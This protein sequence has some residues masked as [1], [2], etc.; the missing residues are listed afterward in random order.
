LGNGTFW[1]KPAAALSDVTWDN[2]TFTPKV[3]TDEARAQ[4]SLNWNYISVSQPEKGPSKPD[5]AQSQP[6]TLQSDRIFE[7]MQSQYKSGSEAEYRK[8][9]MAVVPGVIIG[10]L[11]FTLFGVYIGYSIEKRQIYKRQTLAARY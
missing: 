2:D 6:F 4:A 5:H 11:I 9:L 7:F 1:W 8:W 10:I 3:S